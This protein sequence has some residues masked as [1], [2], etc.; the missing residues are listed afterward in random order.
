M[1]VTLFKFV[2]VA[3][4]VSA[5]PFT[6]LGQTDPNAE[7]NHFGAGARLGF[8]IRSKF[9]NIGLTPAPAPPA[10]GGAVNRAYTDGFVNVDVS[11]NQGGLTW[12]WG[13]QN[14]AQVPGND[15]LVMH[16]N[17]TG[18]ATATSS[19]D[20]SLGYEITYLRDIAHEDWGSWGFKFAFGHS[21]INLRDSQPQTVAASQITDTYPLG[22]VQPPLAPYSGSFNGPGPVVGSTP[23]RTITAL[24]GGALITG[25]R[26]IDASLYDFRLGPSADLRLSK[27]L[28]LQL[29]GGLAVGIV[30]SDFTFSESTTT[31]AGVTSATGSDHRVDCLVGAYAAAELTCRVW[32][33]AS[34]FAGVEFQ[35]LGN[36]QQSASGRVAEL[37]LSQT[38]FCKAG[39]EWRF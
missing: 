21:L 38:V 37:D 27:C 11:G 28:S 23:T 39:F 1:H 29:G 7:W 8:N 32:R 4:A 10:A 25:S 12:N 22:G 31:V 13:Y 26:A 3:A 36:F 24:P 6:S 9:M 14:A 16:A 19:D 35:Y 20:P 2:A 18:G 34:V 30:D 15:T 33:S 5:T 17:S